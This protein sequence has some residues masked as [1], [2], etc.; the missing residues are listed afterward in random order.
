MPQLDNS[1]VHWFKSL[2]CGTICFK[3]WSTYQCILLCGIINEK[4]TNIFFNSK[5]I[6]D[7]YLVAW[8]STVLNVVDSVL[9]FYGS[10]HN[11]MTLK[12]KDIMSIIGTIIVSSTVVNF[13][14]FLMSS[15]ELKFTEFNLDIYHCVLRNTL[16]VYFVGAIE[17][18]KLF[19]I[20]RLFLIIG[21]RRY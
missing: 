16:L 4:V 2:I 7:L 17:N 6:I 8:C 14:T 3:K 12:G 1:R 11:W 13:F 10:Y 18:L 5:Q 19:F 20:C 9:A 21:L 15:V